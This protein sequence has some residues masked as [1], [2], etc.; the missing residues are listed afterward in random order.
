MRSPVLP[1]RTTLERGGWL[2]FILVTRI[3]G[4][5][6]LYEFVEWFAA[7]ALEPEGGDRFP[8]AQG[9]VW[10]APSD[11]LEAGIGASAALALLAR[12]HDASRTK[13]RANL[14]R[15]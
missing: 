4:F 11:G 9:D 5:G 8:G 10:D 3:R 15:A 14:T 6:A 12:L 7:L 13:V 1:R 2:A